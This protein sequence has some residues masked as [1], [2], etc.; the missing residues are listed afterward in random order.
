VAWLVGDHAQERK[1]YFISQ[2]SSEPEVVGYNNM[3][4]L[5]ELYSLNMAIL[6][7]FFLIM[8]RRGPTFSPEKKI[9]YAPF[10]PSFCFFLLAR[11]R[12]FA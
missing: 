8:W 2:I 1:T 6:G 4:D 9:P 11:L 12:K 3:G 10:A 5:L 7:F